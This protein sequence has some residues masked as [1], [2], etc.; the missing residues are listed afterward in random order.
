MWIVRLALARPY[1]FVV[2][3]LVIVLLTPI[4]LM[5]TPT[6]IFPDINIPVVSLVWKY[7]GL[8][9]LE[10]EQRITSNSE[11]AVTT[12]VNDVEHIESI[13]INGISVVKIYFQPN[14]NVQ[15]ALAQTTAIVQTILKSLPPGTT[16]PLVSIFSA[17]TVPVIQIGLTSDSLSEQQLFDF[18]NNF[19]RTQLATV[20][21]AALPYPY[22][23]KQRVVSVDIDS[24]ALQ[25]KGLSP[26]DIVNA[27]DA[28]NLILPSGTV[29]LGS[30]EYLVELN[31]SP[32]S[33]EGLND[34]PIKTV[35]GATIY[36]KDVAHI[37]DGF[38]PQTNIVR[39]NGQRGVLMS[40]YKTGGAST[41]D[42]VD[43]VKKVLQDYS[44][45]LPPSLHLT[46]FF[47]QSVFVRASIQGVLREA[48][49]AACLTAVMILIFL[50]NWKSTLIIAISIPLSILVSILMLSALGE[51]INIMTLGGLAL[52]VGILVD[53]ATVEIENINRNLA[54]GKETVQAI[55]DGAAQIAVPAFVST[56]CICIVFIPMFFLSGVAKF[57]FVPLAEAVIFAMLASYGWS[58][59]IVP[60]MAMYLLSSEDEYDPEKHAGEKQGFFRRYQ[61]GFERAF[62]RFREGYHRGLASALDRSLLFGGCFLGFCVLSVG[63]VTVLGRDFFPK[64]DA[65]QIRL[66]FRARTGL[67]IEETARLADEVDSAIR[68]TIP[69][70]ELQTILDNI[71]VPYSG[72][73]LSYSNSGTFG[74]SDAE[75]M[76]QLKE[77][78]GKPTSA[79]INDLREKLPQL[80]PGVQFFFQPADIVTQ[81][82]N[83]GTPAPIDIA[84]TG[85]DQPGDY[86]VAEKLA[87]EIRHIPGAV[88]VHVQQALDEPTLHLDVDRTRAQSVG[89]QAKD[90][91]Q[92]LL[93]S[94]SSSFQTSPAFWLDPKN[95]VDYNVAVQTPQYR[96]D[97][98]QQLENT[99]VTGAAA[100][101][102]PQILGNLVNVTTTARQAEISHYNVQRMINVYAAVDGRDL[103]TV[104]DQVLKLVDNAEREL[105][106]GSHIEVRGQVQT[107]RTSFRGLAIGLLGA[108]ILAYLLIVV[109]FQSWL[110]PFII[111]T[112]LPGALA[113]ICWILL[114]T[115]TTLSVPSLTGAIMCMGV[116][117][118]NSILM[119][120][121]AREQLS[122]GKSAREAALQA[123]FVR[124]RPV[125]MTALAM[126]IGM[127]PMAIG[128]GEG[129][130][131]NAPLGRA[132]IGGLIF[133]TFATLFF[134][135]CVF[136]MIHGR[137]ERRRH[138]GATSS[139]TLA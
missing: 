26:V 49:I 22:G 38:S 47:D 10:M 62:E 12:L 65:G 107:M 11:R 50:G 56:L 110:D 100:G 1:T 121:F 40:T 92:N 84:V 13:S 90:V 117:T 87:N 18:G 139:P 111:I 2:L 44:S 42:I 102:P 74:T 99:P 19:I 41:L 112:A 122:E 16:P 28:Q 72:I 48:L 29:K 35:N 130:E 67:R 3:A 21:G 59:T 17:S 113:G 106:R 60:T 114:L 8:E 134:V 104:S 105:P 88:D 85:A 7:D 75:I 97:T 71:G 115:H 80:F 127:V 86:V 118:A 138:H 96:V 103:G 68:E 57:L 76:V 69:P 109:N 137:R 136:S 125:L 82:L 36:M 30:L 116:A 128:L 37:R 95:G 5:R 79:Y 31:G 81:I 132:V 78:R 34:L 131:Q 14:A 89:L 15:T 51:T 52:A 63:L 70:N 54:M 39:M 66:H 133:A 91:A 64:V 77:E 43:R 135:P 55:L 119:V 101:T 45:S 9:P 61:Q 27:I 4:V 120:S 23:G 126:I 129:G 83:F 94:L 93:V 73:N 32:V 98:Y 33:I 20:Q 46:T 25:S 24:A 53:D 123:G 108:I 6:D 58:R 124:I